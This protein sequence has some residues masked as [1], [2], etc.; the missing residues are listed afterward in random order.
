[1][2]PEQ[3]EGKAIDARSDIFS[4]GV[5]LYELATGERPFRGDSA[6]AVLS[7]ILK[8]TP[9]PV[10]ELKPELP[11]EISKIVR[12]CLVKDVEHR[13]QS[14]KDV[15]NE[16]EELMRLD[17]GASL[18]VPRGSPTVA[19]GHRRTVAPCRG[20]AAWFFPSPTRRVPRLVNLQPRPP[21]ASR[22]IRRGPDGRMIA[23]DSNRAETGTSGWPW[24]GAA[25]NR[26]A[27]L[28]ERIRPSW[29]ADGSASRSSPNGREAAT[30]TSALGGTCRCLFPR[31]TNSMA[32]MADSLGYS[33]DD[34]S[35][36]LLDSSMSQHRGPPAPSGPESLTRA[37]PDGRLR[38]RRRL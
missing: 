35:G 13:Y 33:R 3:A 17:W 26:T 37:I 21:S 30:Q 4:L 28:Q 14:A 27:D 32:L 1:M 18:P 16:L 24:G 15:R 2:S 36:P 29:S 19:T 11:S 10:T 22:T 20:V 23:Y 8:D 5:V 34:G 38:V 9:L 31:E 7:S 12:R 6:T 25:V